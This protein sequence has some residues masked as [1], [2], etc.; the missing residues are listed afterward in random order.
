VIN[1][2]FPIIWKRNYYYYSFRK[3][4][5][6]EMFPCSPNPFSTYARIIG[7]T[8]RQKDRKTERQ[9]CSNYRTQVEWKKYACHAFGPIEIK[10]RELCELLFC[11]CI[12]SCYCLCFV[13]VFMLLFMFALMF[14]L[15]VWSCMLLCMLLDVFVFMLFMFCVKIFVYVYVR[16][17]VWIMTFVFVVVFVVVYVSV[18]VNVYFYVYVH[19]F[20]LLLCESYFLYLLLFFSLCVSIIVQ[21]DLTFFF[22]KCHW[23]ISTATFFH[24][25]CIFHNELHFE[26]I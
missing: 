17:I 20:F 6:S 15:C 5:Q 12:C 19:V 1:Y 21:L 2:W 4:S 10:E 8:E 22:R 14:M 23:N 16:E 9:K 25:S 11:I 3:F 18:S 26:T 24:L 13:Y 7:Q